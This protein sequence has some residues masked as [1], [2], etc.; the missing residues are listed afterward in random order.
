M[1]LYNTRAR[2]SLHPPPHRARC[3][4]PRSG[5][6]PWD[7][8]QVRDR[9][10]GRDRRKRAGG[11]NGEWRAAAGR[12]QLS[13][14]WNLSEPQAGFRLGRPTPSGCKLPAAFVCQPSAKHERSWKYGS[15]Y[16]GQEVCFPRQL[17][18]TGHGDEVNRLVPKF[19]GA[20]AD[21]WKKM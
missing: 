3:P 15:N 8:Q 19:R 14:P 9:I 1:I 2:V 18:P 10:R 11:L 12:V 16:L 4:A 20:V 21:K 6:K 13:Q 7:C 17:L 5:R